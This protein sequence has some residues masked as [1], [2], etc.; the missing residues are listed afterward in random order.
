MFAPDAK[1]VKDKID[2]DVKQS[3]A[4]TGPDD[5]EQMDKVDQLDELLSDPEIKQALLERV[6]D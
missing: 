1:S 2:D 3:Y 5:S 4:Q 6:G